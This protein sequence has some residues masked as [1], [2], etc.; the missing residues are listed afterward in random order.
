M[1]A[2]KIIQ[3]LAAFARQHKPARKSMDEKIQVEVIDDGPGI[4][5]ENLDKIFNPFFTTKEVR[6]GT[7]LGLSV[8]CGIVQ[9][10]GGH[11]WAEGERGLKASC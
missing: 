7:G 9:Q 10:H 8:S 5:E 3:N 2:R 11:I 1:R 4:P 6:E